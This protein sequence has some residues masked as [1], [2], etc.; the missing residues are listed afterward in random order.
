[1]CVTNKVYNNV[2]NMTLHSFFKTASSLQATLG[3]IIRKA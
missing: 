2:K 1:M 3:F